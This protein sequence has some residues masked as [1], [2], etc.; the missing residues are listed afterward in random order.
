MEAAFNGDPA[1][2]SCEEVIVVYPFVEAIAMQRLAHAPYLENVALIPRIMTEWAHARSGLDL[3]PGAQI[4]W[5]FFVDH[6]T[7]TVIGKTAVIGDH[8]KMYQGVTL[9]AQHSGS[10]MTCLLCWGV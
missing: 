4:G 1:A 8:V 6:C 5:H 7:G 9:G 2:L 10:Y 3:Q